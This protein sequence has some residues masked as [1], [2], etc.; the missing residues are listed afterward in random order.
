MDGKIHVLDRVRQAAGGP[1]VILGE[2]TLPQRHEGGR[3]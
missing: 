1:C 2:T 3:V